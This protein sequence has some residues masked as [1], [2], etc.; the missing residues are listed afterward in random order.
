MDSCQGGDIDLLFQTQ[1][2]EV[3]HSISSNFEFPASTL[4]IDPVDVDPQLVQRSIV[5]YWS[6]ESEMGGSR[7]QKSLVRDWA[8]GWTTKGLSKG[9]ISWAKSAASEAP[10]HFGAWHLPRGS[11]NGSLP[12]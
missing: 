12:A 11:S 2:Q 3:L 1:G 8:E 10:G 9:P 7:K 6:D 4:S 5:N